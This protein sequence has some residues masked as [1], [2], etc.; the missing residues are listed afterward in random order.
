MFANIFDKNTNSYYKSNIYGILSLQDSNN[1]EAIVYNPI[2]EAFE[3]VPYNKTIQVISHDKTGL[4]T[5]QNAYLLKYKLFCK[6]NDYPFKINKF[7]GPIEVL[8]NHEFLAKI[9]SNKKVPKTETNI[10][11]IDRSDKDIWNYLNT[12]EDAN[13]FMKMFAGFHDSFMCDLKFDLENNCVTAI[14]DNS[15]WYGI[16]ELCFESVEDIKLIKPNNHWIYSAS[17]FVNDKYVFWMDEYLETFD[18]ATE[19]LNCS[20]IKAVSLKWRDKDPSKKIY[21]KIIMVD[22]V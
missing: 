18:E 13:E 15:G 11:V 17:L 4:A 9:I 5:Y 16:V 12:Q 19:N 14:F 3:L 21:D 7:F 22:K 20:Y 8:K 6:N 2:V 1:R 10:E